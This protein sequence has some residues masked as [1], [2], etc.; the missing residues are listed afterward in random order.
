[1]KYANTQDIIDRYGEDEL[2]TLAD[3][4]GN[5]VLEQASIDRALNDASRLIDGY[6]AT[7]HELPLIKIPDILVRF[8]VDIAVY[9]LSQE[10]GGATDE[11]RLRYEDA[12]KYLAQVATGSINLAINAGPSAVGG[13]GVVM[14]SEKRQFSRTMLRGL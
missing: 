5:N 1:L 12:V 2:Y 8:C 14:S 13:G 9:M 11:R 10:G 3:R 7:R 4:D 6:V